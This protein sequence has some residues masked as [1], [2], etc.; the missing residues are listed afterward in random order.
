MLA[1]SLSWTA[2]FPFPFLPSQSY[3]SF[4]ENP[5]AQ[6]SP[7]GPTAHSKLHCPP[8]HN[9]CTKLQLRQWTGDIIAAH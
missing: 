7:L 3:G 4:S 1:V 6:S 2:D 8:T 5:L 9:V